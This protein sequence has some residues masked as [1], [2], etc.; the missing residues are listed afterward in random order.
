MVTLFLVKATWS[1]VDGVARGLNMPTR[2]NCHIRMRRCKLRTWA[3][4]THSSE[5]SS[6]QSQF[7]AGAVTCSA[8][9]H[10]SGA[11]W[12]R[13]RWSVLNTW[14]L[15]SQAQK[16]LHSSS[17]PP[18][19]LSPGHCRYPPP[20]SPP[21]SNFDINMAPSPARPSF[22]HLHLSCDWKQTF[23]SWHTHAMQLKSGQSD[24][25]HGSF[26]TLRD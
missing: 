9:Q 21:A 7:H 1:E 23:S 13:C 15:W 17:T 14:D 12:H 25:P 24:T 4:R 20:P 19:P 5:K 8:S 3:I 11:H 2:A 10:L 18:V 6:G 16:E 22:H 26:P